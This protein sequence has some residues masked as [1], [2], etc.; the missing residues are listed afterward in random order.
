MANANK[1]NLIGCNVKVQIDTAESVPYLTHLDY[2]RAVREL[3]EF[4]DYTVLNLAE[5]VGT[6]GIL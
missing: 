4:V 1:D 5:E 3:T 6:S 2:S